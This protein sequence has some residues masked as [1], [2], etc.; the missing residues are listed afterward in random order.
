MKRDFLAHPGIAKY[1]DGLWDDLRGWLASDMARPDS[2]IRA[3][4]PRRPPPSAPAWR[5]TRR[6]AIRSMSTSSAP[7]RASRPQLRDGLSEHIAGT[8]RAWRDEDLVREIEHSVG[9]DLQFIR[10]NG[11]LVGGLI[12]LAL[13]ALTHLL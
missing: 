2:R 8:V 13:Y 10:L 3:S 9:R 5:P 7:S 4:W 6:C 12:G 11:T 1:V